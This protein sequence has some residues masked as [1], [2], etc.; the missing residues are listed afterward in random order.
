MRQPIRVTKI[1]F[2]ASVIGAILSS[3]FTEE[4]KEVDETNADGLLIFRVLRLTFGKNLMLHHL[5]VTDE[6]WEHGFY[7]AMTHVKWQLLRDLPISNHLLQL[8]KR[9]PTHV[10]R[11]PRTCFQFS[12][13]KPSCDEGLAELHRG[14]GKFGLQTKQGT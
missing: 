5:S 8:S 10:R 9:E 3:G 2:L 7:E 14:A 1:C 12:P 11:D 13:Y 4:G 6:D